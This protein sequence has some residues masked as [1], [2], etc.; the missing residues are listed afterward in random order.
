MGNQ[1]NPQDSKT[2]GKSGGANMGQKKPD[3]KGGQDQWQQ[4]EHGSTPRHGNDQE[5]AGD[6]GKKSQD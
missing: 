6:G 1:H 2:P 5:Q 4:R 3:D